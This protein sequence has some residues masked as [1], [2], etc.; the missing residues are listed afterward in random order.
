MKMYGPIN[1]IKKCDVSTSSARCTRTSRSLM[2]HS[3]HKRRRLSSLSSST[4]MLGDGRR[5]ISSYVSESR[6]PRHPRRRI[7]KYEKLNTSINSRDLDDYRNEKFPAEI[8]AR[9]EREYSSITEENRVL[10]NEAFRS[11]LGVEEVNDDIVLKESY[12][13]CL[14]IWS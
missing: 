11:L 10:T 9:M 2:L 7:S 13:Q 3:T 14:D 1:D 4:N 5:Q 12:F 8:L 6:P